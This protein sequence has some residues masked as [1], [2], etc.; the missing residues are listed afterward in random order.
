MF[1]KSLKCSFCGKSAE[2]VEKL[3]AGPRVHIC[4]ECVAAAQRIMRDTNGDPPGGVEPL[5]T[6][7]KKSRA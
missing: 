5:P 3:V 7:S 2:Q 1:G 6:T 4:D